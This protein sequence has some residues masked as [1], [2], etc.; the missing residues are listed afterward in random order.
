VNEVLVNTPMTQLQKVEALCRIKF[1]LEQWLAHS[2]EWYVQ[3]H[4]MKGANEA[5]QLCKKLIDDEVERSRIQDSYLDEEGPSSIGLHN[6][7]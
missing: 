6:M 2:P 4:T 3:L 7:E 1:Q 5:Y